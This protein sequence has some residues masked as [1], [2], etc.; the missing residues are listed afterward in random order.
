MP[1]EVD[2]TPVFVPWLSIVSATDPSVLP[3][4]LRSEGGILLIENVLR[5]LSGSLSAMPRDRPRFF[6]GLRTS[7]TLGWSVVSQ[8]FTATDRYGSTVALPHS[9]M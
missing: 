9:S 4:E 5:K 1:V 7:R 2:G 3:P 8:S 6:N